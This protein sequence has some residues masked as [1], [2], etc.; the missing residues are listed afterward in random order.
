[1]TQQEAVKEIL[2]YAVALNTAAESQREIEVIECYLSKAVEV[3][4]KVTTMRSLCSAYFGQCDHW[5]KRSTGCK[6]CI[7]TY[8]ERI[9]KD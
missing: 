1:M 4:M 5:D 6:F 8:K 2:D 7:E 9:I 3:I